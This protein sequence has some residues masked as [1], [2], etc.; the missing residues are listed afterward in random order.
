[1]SLPRIRGF[2][3]NTLIDWP[4]RLAAE[5]FL[6]GCNLRCP[7]CHAGYLL[8][9][10]PEAETFELEHIVAHLKR[11]EGWLD[12]VVVSGGEPTIHP[13]LPGLLRRFKAAGFP[14]KVDTNGTQPE[15]L[16][17]VLGAGL[18]DFVAMDVKAPFERYA[19]VTRVD[20]DTAEIEASIHL[21]AA[22]GL[23]HEF[24]TTF[25]RSLLA[26]SDI[27]ALRRALPPG[28]PYRVQAFV[29]ELAADPC[30]R[31]AS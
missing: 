7:Y 27:E 14:V 9:S 4:G 28:S 29:P 3:P 18:V 2:L 11:E 21:I 24:R 31:R 26:D 5:V 12:G 17:A 13:E 22:S 19:A 8:T 6:E 15:M 20:A 23:P 25:V 10:P 30:L 1:M 16:A